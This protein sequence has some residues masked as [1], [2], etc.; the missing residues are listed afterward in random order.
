MR[1]ILVTI[2]KDY[3]GFPLVSLAKHSPNFY[4]YTVLTPLNMN[5][6]EFY[7]DML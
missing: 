3:I 7:I 6:Y 4:V 2:M 1:I 5:S